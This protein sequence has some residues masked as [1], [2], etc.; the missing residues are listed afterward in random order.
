M[1]FYIANLFSQKEITATSAD[2]IVSSLNWECTASW[3]YGG[4]DGLTREQIAT[5][6]L[7]E[8]AQADAVIVMSYPHGTS[9]RGGGRW[10]ELGYGLGL[11]KQGF[12]IGHYEN[13][14]CH[15][16]SVKVYPSLEDFILDQQIQHTS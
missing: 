4:E 9:H 3:V 15:H 6:D 2:T 14:F 16:P 1:K 13:V 8:V 5:T 7:D 11:G 10:V 12:V